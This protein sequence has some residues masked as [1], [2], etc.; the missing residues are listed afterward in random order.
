MV[1][2]CLVKPSYCGCK[3]LPLEEHRLLF[4]GGWPVAAEDETK[5]LSR[6]ARYSQGDPLRDNETVKVLLLDIKAGQHP[7]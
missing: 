5:M 6:E 1:F 7:A 4:I 2:A 3:A